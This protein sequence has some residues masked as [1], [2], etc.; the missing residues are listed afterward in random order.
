MKLRSG[1]VEMKERPVMKVVRLL[2]DMATELEK[3]LQDDKSVHEQ[4]DCWCKSNNEEKT[5]A[6]ETG[7]QKEADL[8]SRLGEAAARMDSLTQKR[9][10]TLDE[11]NSDVAALEKA[12]TLRMKENKDFHAQEVDLQEAIK[13]CDQ[14][15]TVLAKHNPEFAQVQQVAQK[16]Q[17]AQ[18]LELSTRSR[19]PQDVLELRA[20]LNAAK[21]GDSAFLAVPGYKSY[22][23][24]SGS[25]F[26][27]LKQMKS[28]FE[29]DLSDAQTKEKKTVEGHAQLK[30]AKTDEIDA[31]R[32]LKASL[33]QQI[34]EL[35]EAHAQ[36]FKELGDTQAQLELDRTFLGNL[37]KK[38]SESDAEFEQRVKDRNTEILAVRDTIKILNADEAFDNF[39]KTVNSESF[40]QNRL[41]S[42]GTERVK[43]VMSVLA[44]ASAKT[45]APELALL[46]SRLSLDSFD[47]VKE[48][49]DKMVVQLKKQQQDE[50]EHRDWCIDEFARNDRSATENNERKERLQTKIADHEKNIN[51]LQT[52]IE[53]SKAA[54]DKMQDEMRRASETREAENADFQ[55]TVND[56]RLSQVILQKAL[57]RMQKVYSFVQDEPQVGAA[58]IATSGNHTDPGN[59]PARFTEYNQHSGGSRVVSLIS[60]II[61][62]SR[63]M[64]NEAIASEQDG[65]QAYENYMKDSNQAITVYSEKQMNMKSALARNKEDH[66]NSN[67]D[68]KATV[69]T[70]GELHDT[71]GA[72]HGSCD[73]L[74]QNFDA[75]QAARTEEMNALGEAKGIL[76][77]MRE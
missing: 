3:D 64:E 27:I 44:S 49:I 39:G 35:K 68:L 54:V 23:S 63:A 52:E 72:L 5:N 36:A 56:Q 12:N 21:K 28:D 42:T 61:A 16:L 77:G 1:S 4:L 59:G 31:G 10:A 50:V 41:V 75:R 2:E 8:K 37:K 22:A 60:N 14:A 9:K 55:Q 25:I 20:F 40:L 58:H 57:A 17:M 18:V 46:A 66:T 53:A 29:K 7:E 65:Q 33:D 47:K 34:G 73:F 30:A 71:K 51:Y 32:K 15:V 70:L 45:G 19:R 43:H 76:S 24:Q 74:T 62:E 69:E 67:V 13:A 11:V 26:G 38:C 48:E 6:I